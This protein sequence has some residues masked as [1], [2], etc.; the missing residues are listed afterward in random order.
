MQRTIKKFL[1]LFVLICTVICCVAFAACGDKTGGGNNNGDEHVCQDECPECGKCLTDCEEPECADKCEGHGGNTD[2]GNTDDPSN[3]GNDDPNPQPGETTPQA[4]SVRINL[5]S[6]LSELPAGVVAQAYNGETKVGDPMPVTGGNNSLTL[7]NE[8]GY[9][10]AL[11]NLPDYL[12]ASKVNFGKNA[13]ALNMNV[14]M[15]EV[16]YTVNVEAPGVDLTGVTVALYNLAEEKVKDDIALDGETATFTAEAGIYSAGLE[17]IDAAYNVEMATLGYLA[18]AREG[19]INVSVN[20]I[21]VTIDKDAVNLTSVNIS[22]LTVN[23]KANGATVASAQTNAQGVAEVAAAFGDYEIEIVGLASGYGYV[24]DAITDTVEQATVYIAQIPN[25]GTAFYY[26]YQGDWMPYEG[27]P[28]TLTANGRYVVNA[29]TEEVEL[30]SSGEESTETKLVYAIPA[31]QIN[32]YVS[33]MHYYTVSWTSSSVAFRNV[34][35]NNP[36][37]SNDSSV[38]YL[39]RDN[40]T[41]A[42]EYNYSGAVTVGLNNKFIINVEQSEGPAEGDKDNPYIESAI[43]GTHTAKDAARNYAYFELPSNFD[44][45]AEGE[46][47][48]YELTFGANLS[49]YFIQTGINDTQQSQTSGGKVQPASMDADSNPA[50]SYIY[51]AR[52]DDTTTLSFTL[53]KSTRPAMPGDTAETAKPAAKDTE[54][55]DNYKSAKTVWY[56]FEATAGSYQIRTY[57]LDGGTYGSVSIYSN[58]SGTGLVKTITSTSEIVTLGDQTYYIAVTSKPAVAGDAG[59][60]L[61]FMIS[62]YEV[63]EGMAPESPLT[64]EVGN[65]TAHYEQYYTGKDDMP[66]NLYY[67]FTA[68]EAGTFTYAGALGTSGFYAY[69]YSNAGYTT[70]L[71]TSYGN[72]Q[73][74]ASEFKDNQMVQV[75]ASIEM[76]EGQ[77]VYIRLN[78][79]EPAP[80]YFNIK[81]IPKA[82][83]A[84]YDMSLGT[85]LYIPIDSTSSEVTLNLKNVAAGVYELAYELSAST[86]AVLALDAEGSGFTVSGTKGWGTIE[87]KSGVTAIILTV[88]GYDKDV[89]LTLTLNKLE[90]LG[91]GSPYQVT[92]IPDNNYSLNQDI[93]L[94]GVEPGTYTLTLTHPNG[95]Y[96]IFNIYNGNSLLVS[97]GKE[98]SYTN[99][100]VEITIPAGCNTLTFKKNGMGMPLRVTLLLSA[101]GEDPGIG[102]GGDEAATDYIFGVGYGGALYGYEVLFS[103]NAKT[104]G[105]DGTVTSGSYELQLSGCDMFT[106]YVVE[107]DGS[108]VKTVDGAM[109][110]DIIVTLTSDSIIRIYG[111]SFGI[112][113]ISLMLWEA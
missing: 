104:I 99:I 26:D 53:T 41:F 75:E 34:A 47:Q 94:L 97:I 88:T 27:T 16:E 36:I 5:P 30:L 113:P 65:N 102:G 40:A 93:K 20:K 76:T 82:A 13:M 52:T 74:P 12:T 85:P 96:D 28:Y 92:L 50:H 2:P 63:I 103:D 95:G 98:L 101:D 4:V 23:L 70:T 18:D 61:G 72:A 90:G 7:P 43:A 60:D 11:E 35:S 78:Y 106:T 3:P 39:I 83:A 19:T 54:C 69:M 89:T 38:K 79:W 45:D 17:G 48:W 31:I 67:K 55:T 24:C 59:Y 73:I 56:Y 66:N 86:K 21:T 68:P 81:F 46:Y 109:S 80:A 1:L 22:G 37:E 14:T 44:K 49:V 100:S 112:D 58:A 111:Y 71:P 84:E 108:I 9:S 87:V 107:V 77:T 105:M 29:R 10:L 42:L 91:V 33:G 25:G 51:I 6:I 15:A 57:Q 110:H 8:D 32:S 64:A 62:E